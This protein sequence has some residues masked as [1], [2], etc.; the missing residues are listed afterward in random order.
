VDHEN[1][2]H[3]I[4]W[5]PHFHHVNKCVFFS[6]ESSLHRNCEI[7]SVI[8]LHM[9]FGMLNTDVAKTDIAC[10]T[11]FRRTSITT[12]DKVLFFHPFI[13]LRIVSTRYLK[14]SLGL[15]PQWMVI[16]STYLKLP[17]ISTCVLGL[18]NTLFGHTYQLS[19]DTQ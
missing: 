8:L 15:P 19:D 13:I 18:K 4:I 1:Q 16:P 2:V 12:M 9:F 5:D 6:S 11:A 7:A 14:Q 17:L 3:P 10:A